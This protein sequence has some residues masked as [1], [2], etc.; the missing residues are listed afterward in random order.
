MQYISIYIHHRLLLHHRMSVLREMLMMGY[1][2]V[3][4]IM[5]VNKIEERLYN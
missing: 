2:M 3:K 4:D 1:G 5:T